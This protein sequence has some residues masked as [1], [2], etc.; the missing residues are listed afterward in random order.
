MWLFIYIKIF[1]VFTV[2]I[3]D[4]FSRIHVRIILLSRWTRVNVSRVR[5]CRIMKLVCL[6]VIYSLPELTPRSSQFQTIH[7][8]LPLTYS[9]NCT[10]MIMVSRHKFLQKS[11]SITRS[12]GLFW[13]VFIFLTANTFSVEYNTFNNLHILFKVL[14]TMQQGLFFKTIIIIIYVYNIE[15]SFDDYTYMQLPW[16]I[17]VSFTI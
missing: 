4:H 16:I 3:L 13:P 2:I 8:Y 12:R 17:Y 7:E 5:Y 14:K 1:N 15:M 9:L 10:K 6:S 11:T